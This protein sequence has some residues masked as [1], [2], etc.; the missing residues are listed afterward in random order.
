MSQYTRSFTDYEGDGHDQGNLYFTKIIR[1]G[2]IWRFFIYDFNAN[3]GSGV[4]VNTYSQWDGNRW[5][6]TTGWNQYEQYNFSRATSTCPSLG[7]VRATRTQIW[8]GSTWSNVQSGTGN[9]LG[10]A[11]PCGATFNWKHS[12]WEWIVTS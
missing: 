4:W 6:N 8:N 5:V 7:T 12:Y 11:L 1:D 9:D 2:G 10:G 3:S